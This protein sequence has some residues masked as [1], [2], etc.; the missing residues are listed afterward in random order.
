M[1]KR[2]IEKQNLK[3]R[4]RSTKNKEQENIRKKVIK[5]YNTK[6]KNHNVT[7]R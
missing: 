2:T 6:G 5:E 7:R 4:K 1:T 3:K